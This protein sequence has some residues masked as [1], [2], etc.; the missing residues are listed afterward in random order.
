MQPAAGGER[1]RAHACGPSSAHAAPARR[2]WQPQAVKWDRPLL[3]MTCT[4]GELLSTSCVPI[5]TPR[6]YPGHGFGCSAPRSRMRAHSPYWD[7]SSRGRSGF[8]GQRSVTHRPHIRPWDTHQG[9]M[10][11]TAHR[12]AI[13]APPLHRTRTAH[14]HRSHATSMRRSHR[15]PPSARPYA[16][17]CHH[18]LSWHI[19]TPCRHP[20]EATPIQPSPRPERPSSPRSSATRRCRCLCRG[21]QGMGHRLQDEGNPVVPRRSDESQSMLCVTIAG[22]FGQH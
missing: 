9:H 3:T 7:S 21:V 4:C 1:A 20:A 14:M 8:E 11:P 2:E 22:P 5:Q 10:P 12:Y 16:P 15:P 17:L 18:A 13:H 6:A 19:A